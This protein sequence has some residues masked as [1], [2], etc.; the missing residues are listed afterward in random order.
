MRLWDRSGKRIGL[1]AFACVLAISSAELACWSIVER[2][3]AT[4]FH[5]RSLAS[6][7]LAGAAGLMAF[8]LGFGLPPLGANFLPV[9]AASWLFLEH[10]LRFTG[11]RGGEGA[12]LSVLLALPVAGAL[13]LLSMRRPGLVLALGVSGVSLVLVGVGEWQSRPE[14]RPPPSRGGPDVVFLV[15][16][17]TRRDHLS[18]YGY[19]HETTPK[20]D[21][22]AADA[23]IYED[24]WSVA[25]WTSRVTPRC[26]RGCF[27]RSM[28][29]TA[30]M[31]SRSPMV[32]RPCPV[33]RDAG[34]RTA[35]FAANPNLH[36]AGWSRD[37]DLYGA[38]W[39]R[40]KHTLVAPLNQL[41]RGAGDP[42]KLDLDSGIVLKQAM[43]WWRDNEDG[44][45]FL[46]INLMDPHAPYQAP[47]QDR[48]KFVGDRDCTRAAMIARGGRYEYADTTITHDEALCIAALYDAEVHTMDRQIG[49]FFDWLA[50][51]GELGRTLVVITSDHGERLG[52]G[53]HVGHLLEMDQHL[54]R[55]PLILRYPERLGPVPSPPPRPAH[56]S[57][58]LCSRTGG[59]G[60]ARGDGGAFAGQHLD[61]TLRRPASKLRVVPETHSGRG[62]PI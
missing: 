43:R 27:P 18:L 61:R 14:A 13:C 11:L 23:R 54:L 38:P 12:W 42:W 44:R 19:P 26:S 29:R 10:L 45:R 46:F 52:E 8:L 24:A 1:P 41:I 57:A 40:G 34:Y 25:P 6:L 22:L 53:G 36:S 50:E 9:A 32:R 21:A 5:D 58:R 49:E 47:E 60:D 3:P 20:L 7:M 59:R 48:Q 31:Q 39:I 15:M 28:M 17:T 4:R 55:V 30:M 16:D 51:R 35:G 56:G 37:F 2:P 62:S 33:L